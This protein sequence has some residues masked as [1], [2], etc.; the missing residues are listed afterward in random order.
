MPPAPAGRRFPG[1]QAALAQALQRMLQTQPGTTLYEVYAC[2]SPGAA[3]ESGWLQLI[4]RVVSASKFILEPVSENLHQLRFRH[5]KK[6]EDY[7]LRPEWLQDMIW[8]LLEKCLPQPLGLHARVYNPKKNKQNSCVSVYFPEKNAMGLAFT[9]IWQRMIGKQEMR[10][11]MVG[12]D[13]AGKTT[14][15]YK[16]KL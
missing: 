10:I 5:Q 12:L 16:L 13:A 11:L 1:G 2:P 4:G 6:E 3:F 15:L 14:I 8:M 7:V 9:K